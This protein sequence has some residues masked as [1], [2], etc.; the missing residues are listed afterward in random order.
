M[1]HGMGQSQMYPICI[2]LAP[3]FGSFSKAK[4]SHVK[5][6]PSQNAV[7]ILVTTTIQNQS[8]ITTA[9]PEKSSPHEITSFS[10]PKNQNQLKKYRLMK[11]SL[12]AKG[13]KREEMHVK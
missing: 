8:Y 13:S 7:P 5:Y 11:T 3:L 4:V 1:K 6:C 10:P 2:N 9:K 12:H